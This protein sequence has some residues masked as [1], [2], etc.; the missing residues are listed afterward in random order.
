MGGGAIARTEHPSLPTSIQDVSSSEI[1]LILKNTFTLS[2]EGSV[3][4]AVGFEASSKALPRAVLRGER[5]QLLGLD[6]R[7]L[8]MSS[9]PLSE[10]K[11][12]GASRGAELCSGDE[13]AMVDSPLFLFSQF[14]KRLQE[15]IRIPIQNTRT[16]RRFK[17]CAK[18][19]QQPTTRPSSRY[20]LF[21]TFIQVLHPVA[22]FEA[23]YKQ[24]KSFLF[25][26]L[27]FLVCLFELFFWINKSNCKETMADKKPSAVT[28]GRQFIKK[29]YERL[30]T[31]PETMHRFYQVIIFGCTC[32]FF[33]F[34]FFSSSLFK[35]NKSL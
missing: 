10:S 22:L 30:D 31:Q 33:F 24:A 20:K 23:A 15:K 18:I 11:E 8:N 5:V 35:K 12:F 4:V 2:C 16:S 27:W 29:Y 28:V 3:V 17:W 9:S 14:S 7:M 26:V 34:L 6:W 32:L 21:L 1:G 19:Q 13:R 25:S